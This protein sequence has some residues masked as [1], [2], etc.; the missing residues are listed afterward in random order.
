MKRTAFLW[1]G[2]TALVAFVV[3]QWVCLRLDDRANEAFA[4]T[5]ER[6]AIK[7]KTRDY[8]SSVFGPPAYEYKVK[9]GT[10]WVYTPG[11]SWTFWRHECKIGFDSA[12]LVDGWIVRS[13]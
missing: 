2:C 6:K 12:G 8:V 4:T 7:G 11:P 13:D 9:D 10:I 5:A 1:L 3:S